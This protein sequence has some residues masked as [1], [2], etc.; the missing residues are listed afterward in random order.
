MYNVHTRDIEAPIER[1]AVHLDRLGSPDDLL[2]PA[3]AW[4]PMVLDRPLAA[5]ADGGHG[6]IRYRV[7]QHE[8][9]RRVR[10]EFDPRIGIGG[11]H[12]FSL[13]ALARGR[14][15]VTHELVCQA[16]GHMRL[17][18]PVIETLHDAVLEDLLDNAERLA[19]GTVRSPARWSRWVRLWRLL[20][21]RPPVTATEM[22]AG[23]TLVG[24][25]VETWGGADRLGVFDAWT[26]PLVRGVPTDPH[27]WA[28]AIFRGRPRL[29][30][31]S[32]VAGRPLAVTDRE[33]LIGDD[34]RYFSFRASVHVGD[35]AVT[36][37]SIARATAGAGRWYL[38]L[39]GRFHPFVVRALLRRAARRFAVPAVTAPPA[40]PEIAA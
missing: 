10:F 29:V 25:V 40:A 35:G 27:V 17:L 33:E 1:L 28:D 23:A 21:E 26:V 22:P 15:R 19:T 18:A 11:Y 20:L 9:G 14:T 32:V 12:E 4:W 24:G 37:T 30:S 8:P 38:S 2:W 34:E 6:D 16:R 36:V 3:P 13:T 31:E 5:G 7:S 39:V